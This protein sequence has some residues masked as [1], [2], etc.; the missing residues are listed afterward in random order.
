MGIHK[1]AATVEIWVHLVIEH[2]FRT[3]ELARDHDTAAGSGTQ[4]SAA[5]VV[6]QH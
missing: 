2:H 3:S 4:P 6:V 5:V 1:V